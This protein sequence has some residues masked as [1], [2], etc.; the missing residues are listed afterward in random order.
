MAHRGES[1]VKA[2]RER[3]SLRHRWL[4]PSLRRFSG[5]LALGFWAGSLLFGAVCDATPG[6]E[7]PHLSARPSQQTA[8]TKLIGML[9]TLGT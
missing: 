9:S 8:V 3:L 7:S 2:E 1:S 6:T 4:N 5:P